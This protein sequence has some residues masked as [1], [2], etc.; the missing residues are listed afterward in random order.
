MIQQTPRVP[1]AIKVTPSKTPQQRD[2]VIASPSEGSGAVLVPTPGA[3]TTVL[4]GIARFGGPFAVPLSELAL[5]AWFAIAQARHIVD[6]VAPGRAQLW[7]V[8]GQ[9][10]AV[11]HL[12]AAIVGAG[13]AVHGLIGVLKALRRQ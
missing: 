6:V 12:V 4:G 2:P 8:G 5:G 1:R 13:A 7:R 11:W 9:G 10:G 3:S